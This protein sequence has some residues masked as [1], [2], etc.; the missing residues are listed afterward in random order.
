MYIY[1]SI[2]KARAG[3]PY[4]G[5]KTEAESVAAEKGRASDCREMTKTI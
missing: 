1:A 5:R 3:S 2:L 4:P